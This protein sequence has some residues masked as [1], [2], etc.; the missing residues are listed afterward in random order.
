M[1]KIRSFVPEFSMDGKKHGVA[2]ISVSDSSELVTELGEYV[3]TEGT[4]AWDIEN[5]DFYG[6]KGSEWVKQT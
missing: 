1:V 6:L 5:G 3:F 4:I 2:E